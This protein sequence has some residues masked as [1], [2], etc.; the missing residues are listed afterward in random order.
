MQ[1]NKLKGLSRYKLCQLKSDFLQKVLSN[2]L[3]V[4]LIL[5]KQFVSVMHLLKV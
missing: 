5:Q 3:I 2:L 1:F 4:A